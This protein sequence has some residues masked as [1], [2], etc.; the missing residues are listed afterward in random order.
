M[1]RIAMNRGMTF[2]YLDSSEH[3]LEQFLGDTESEIEQEYETDQDYGD[4]GR[5]YD[6]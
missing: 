5:D 6:E 3:T 1:F 2:V 4:S